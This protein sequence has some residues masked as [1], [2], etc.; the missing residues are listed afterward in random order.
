VF[1][2]I[3]KLNRTIPVRYAF[4]VGDSPEDNS[5]AFFSSAADAQLIR[6]LPAD[7]S[8]F[9][10]AYAY[11][12]RLI[13]QFST[14]ILAKK[15][16]A[17]RY[18]SSLSPEDAAVSTYA[19]QPDLLERR[20]E[21]IKSHT[22]RSKSE[23]GKALVKEIEGIENS[24]KS[25]LKVVESHENKH[26]LTEVFHRIRVIKHAPELKPFREKPIE[27]APAAQLPIPTASRSTCNLSPECIVAFGEAASSAI[28]ASHPEAY[29]KFA[30]YDED[31]GCFRVTIGDVR[32]DLCTLRFNDDMLLTDIR[33]STKL[34]VTT[35][36]HS[37]KFLEQYWEPVVYAVGHFYLPQAETILVPKHPRS[38]RQRLAGYSLTAPGPIF[39][40]IKRPFE[41]ENQSTW[42]VR[43]S[44]ASAEQ[45]QDAPVGSEV[46]CRKPEL[47]TYH[48]RTGFVTKIFP[49]PMYNEYEIDFGRGLGQLKLLRN[50]FE[51][52][53]KLEPPHEQTPATPQ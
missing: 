36:Y 6:G 16:A 2:S 4:V 47:P 43:T 38:S 15:A 24:I 33:P 50:E 41:K 26:K 21:A 13:R 12:N 51:V 7:Y 37:A 46:T 45:S 32:D 40:S 17:Y 22:G 30:E 29:L 23:M 3:Q 8:S 35:P 18:A 34:A 52:N 9:G 11:A 28:T 42:T 20:M 19:E 49:R 48:Q 27:P 39:A 5:N 31:M 44:K 10:E 1:I 14:I 53:A 25:L